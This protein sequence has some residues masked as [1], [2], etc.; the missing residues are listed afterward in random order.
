[1]PRPDRLFASLS[2]HT[3]HGA[4]ATTSWGGEPFTMATDG[5]P[6]YIDRRIE[7]F[8]QFSVE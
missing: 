8:E 1:L 5:R 6:A 2:T 4:P 3:H 7:L